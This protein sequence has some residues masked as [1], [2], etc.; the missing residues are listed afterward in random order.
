MARRARSRFAP[1]VDRVEVDSR[2][3]AIQLIQSGRVKVN[4]VITRNPRSL[5]A[6]NAAV[7]LTRPRTL[8]GTTKLRAALA[9]FGPDVSGRVCLD[10]GAAAGG[11]TTAL[12]EAGA[13]RVYAVDTGYGQLLGSLR[14]DQRVVNLERTNLRD[15][16][17]DTVPEP[18]GVVCLDLSYVALADALPQLTGVDW[19]H[20]AE[21]VA[22]VKPTFEL[23]AGS[24]VTDPEPLAKARAIA[25]AAAESC[26][27]SVLGSMPAPVTGQAGAPEVFLH[28][29]RAH[30]PGSRP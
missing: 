15:L 18:V 11:F 10:V 6:P 12:L 22:L 20:D 28:G 25:A 1:L 29:R 3:E 14:Q 9:R 21:L 30:G 13:A 2:R 23:G 8:R 4:G 17:P 5:V 24:L 19:R 16:G 27:W 7:T 26:G